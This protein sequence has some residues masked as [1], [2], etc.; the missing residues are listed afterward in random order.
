[1]KHLEVIS[2]LVLPER[3]ILRLGFECRSK[4]EDVTSGSISEGWGLL[5]GEEK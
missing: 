1:M 2:C 5:D 4:Q 3:Q